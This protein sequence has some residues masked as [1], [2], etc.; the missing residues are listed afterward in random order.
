[1]KKRKVLQSVT[2]M[3]WIAIFM[4]F[5]GLSLG[6]NYMIYLSIFIAITAGFFHWRSNLK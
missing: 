4:F 3:Q 6:K 1:M 2:I 5:T